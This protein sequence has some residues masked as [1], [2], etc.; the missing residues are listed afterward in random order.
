MV[1]RSI[2]ACLCSWMVACCALHGQDLQPGP[3]SRA[4]PLLVSGER[5]PGQPAPAEVRTTEAPAEP[6]QGP[7]QEP[8][9]EGFTPGPEFQTWV[10]NLVR[11]ELPH[12]YEKR[13]NWG[14]TTRSVSGVSI[15][16]DDGR[17]KT[18][19]KYRQANDGQWQ[20]YSVKLVDPEENFAVRVANIRQVANGRV[21]MEITAVANLEVFGRQALWEHGV[22]LLSISGEADAR[23]R[24]RATTDV[25]T[26]LDVTR[27]PPDIFLSPEVTAAKLE[28]LDFK[29]RRISDLSGPVVRSLSHSVR[30]ALE[31]KLAKDNTKL[32]ARLNKSIDKK[33]DKLKLSAADLFETKWAGLLGEQP[34]APPPEQ[35]EDR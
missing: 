21:Q 9:S 17:L 31:E 30:E 33:E 12:K 27:L 20:M 24:L 25:A 8:A 28:I 2:T 15:Q 16:L 5:E 10:S 23:V 4:P 3:A 18:H 14:H 1:A 22:Q 34:T 26:R 19:R 29:L 6:V 11:Q 13:K 7:G 35:D 32:V